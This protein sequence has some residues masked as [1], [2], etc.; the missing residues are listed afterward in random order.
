MEMDSLH[1]LYVDE[2]KDL[3][4]AETQIQKALPRLVRAATHPELKQLLSTHLEQTERQAER[5][6]RICENLGEKPTGKKCVGMQGLLEEAR[7]LIQEKPEREVLDAGL[8]AAQQ[9][10]EHYEM[11]GYGCVRTYARLLGRE[12]D[13]QLLQQT[14]DEEKATDE[15][16]SELAERTIN[17]QA[18]EAGEE[19]AEGARPAQRATKRATKGA[20]KGAA[21]RVAKGATKGASKSVAKGAATRGASGG[22]RGAAK[23]AGRGAGTRAAAKGGGRPA[24]A[25]GT[26]R[27]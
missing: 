7:E 20:A 13:A 11:A 25:L 10:V 18:A 5:L 6:A 14:L 22:G 12:E 23:G 19:G 8:I 27:R 2:L 26:K 16:L 17:V 3:Y 24:R 1:A 21:R 9:H 15:Q 4:S